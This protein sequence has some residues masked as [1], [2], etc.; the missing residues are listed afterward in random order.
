M[1]PNKQNA[2]HE[3]RSIISSKKSVH[4]EK[5]KDKGHCKTNTL[6]FASNNTYIIFLWN[7]LSVGWYLQQVLWK[8]SIVNYL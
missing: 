2:G 6:F 1:V 4:S 8:K 7:Y 5:K 3:D